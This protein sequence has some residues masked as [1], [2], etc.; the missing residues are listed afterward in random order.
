ME[1]LA[2]T[3]KGGGFPRH[4]AVLKVMEAMTGSECLVAST[5]LY[6]SLLFPHFSTSHPQLWEL[7][8]S[9]THQLAHSRVVFG[10]H[11]NKMNTLISC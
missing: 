10:I 2:E 7:L 3:G 4:I 1:S 8:S 11:K 6:K 9:S 5:A